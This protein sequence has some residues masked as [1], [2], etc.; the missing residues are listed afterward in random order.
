MSGYEKDLDEMLEQNNT[1]EMPLPADAM[2]VVLNE[3]QARML[4]KIA[5]SLEIIASVMTKESSEYV[6]EHFA[7]DDVN[8]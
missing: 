3:F 1:A 4:A 7:G 2:N 8:A 5:E 6:H